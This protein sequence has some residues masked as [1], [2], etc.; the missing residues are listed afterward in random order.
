M[1]TIDPATSW[2]DIVKIPTFELEEETLGN[3]EYIDNNLPGF[4]SCLT[5]YGYEDTRVHAKSYLTTVM[6]LN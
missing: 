3:D 6:S 1:P 4:A 5:E 2:S